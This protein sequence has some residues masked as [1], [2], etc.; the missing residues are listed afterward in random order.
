M[1]TG[2]IEETSNW[3]SKD[4]MSQH[5]LLSPKSHSIKSI[6]P[7]QVKI[8]TKENKLIDTFVQNVGLIKALE[9]RL[10]LIRL[11]KCPQGTS[12]FHFFDHQR[13]DMD[14]I[15]DRILE[16]KYDRIESVENLIPLP[17]SF[18]LSP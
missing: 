3:Q 11:D 15:T 9:Q 6:T 5:R 14:F 17:T 18:P 8:A 12:L 4:I 10:R 13:Q 2:N 1:P 7:T 16:L